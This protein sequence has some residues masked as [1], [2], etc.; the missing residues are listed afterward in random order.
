[1]YTGNSMWSHVTG[2]PFFVLN[3]QTQRFFSG[4]SLIFGETLFL[5]LI[6]SHVVIFDN[7]SLLGPSNKSLSYFLH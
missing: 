3:L 4:G 5:A 7:I 2:E 6:F 1:M